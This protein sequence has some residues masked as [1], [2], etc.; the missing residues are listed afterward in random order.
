MSEDRRQKAV[1]FPIAYQLPVP[2]YTVEALAQNL[3]IPIDF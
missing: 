2:M 1:G 3:F